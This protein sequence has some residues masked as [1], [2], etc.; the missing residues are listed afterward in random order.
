MPHETALIATIAAGVGLAFALGFAAARLRMPPLIG[1][2]L[3]GVAV[4]PFTPGFVADTGLARQLA[5]IGVILLMFGVG[6]HFSL[7][8]LLSVRRIAVPGAAVQIA[9]ATALGAAVSRLWGGSWGSAIVFG[10]CLSV[11]STVVLVLLPALAGLLGGTSGEAA[12][13]PATA[14]LSGSVPVAIG[15]TLAKVAA[16]IALMTV[17]GRRAVPWLLERVART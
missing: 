1:Y 4:G 13:G 16:F 6:M 14:G 7:G 3:A 17:V 11:A 12:A 9:V 8:D 2:L 5:E 10:L 15:L